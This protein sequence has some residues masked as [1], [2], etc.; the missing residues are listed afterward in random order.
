MFLNLP[1]NLNIMVI[2]LFLSLDLHCGMPFPRKYGCVSLSTV[3]RVILKL[4]SLRKLLLDFWTSNLAWDA[5]HWL[6]LWILLFSCSRLIAI[7][8]WYCVLLLLYHLY[9]VY[10]YIFFNDLLSRKWSFYV[11]SYCVYM[12]LC[13]APE[14]SMVRRYIRQWI[15]NY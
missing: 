2:E 4:I 9:F 1:F 6:S 10:I 3:L 11:W 14:N 15:I 5:I 7:I 8:L 12:F 13:K